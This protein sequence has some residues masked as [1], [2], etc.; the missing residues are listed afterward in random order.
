MLA[1]PKGLE[2]DFIPF[3]KMRKRREILFIQIA[4]QFLVICKYE[5]ITNGLFARIMAKLVHLSF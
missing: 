1:Q 4:D 3:A 5:R 2:A